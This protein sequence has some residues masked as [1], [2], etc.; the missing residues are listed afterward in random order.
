MTDSELATL[1]AKIAE[2]EKERNAA[3]ELAEL[4][5][6]KLQ[7]ARTET[8]HYRKLYLHAE[9]MHRN[10]VL[11]N[12]EY[13]E[14]IVIEPMQSKRART[15]HDWIWTVIFLIA[16]GCVAYLFGWVLVWPK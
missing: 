13:L 1:Y 8:E 3:H 9:R 2:L 7:D 11:P 5:A 15:I 4:T 6:M 10:P 14:N 12:V 16:V